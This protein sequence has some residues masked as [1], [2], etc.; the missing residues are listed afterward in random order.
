M[1][2]QKPRNDL[3][4]KNGNLHYLDYSKEREWRLTED[5]E[6]SYNEIA[7]I[8]VNSIDGL[9]SI[10]DITNNHIDYSLIIPMDSYKTIEYLWP[11]HLI[12]RGF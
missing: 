12:N 1:Q 4:L 6:F 11:T 7:F 9:Q 10:T 8:V 3:T 5:L 2:T